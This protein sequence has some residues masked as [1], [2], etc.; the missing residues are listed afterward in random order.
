MTKNVSR[1]ER[2]QN[3]VEQHLLREEAAS[4]AHELRS[5]CRFCPACA[6]SGPQPHASGR[7]AA[8]ESL[9]AGRIVQPRSGRGEESTVRPDAD[10]LGLLIG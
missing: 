10:L 3:F 8:P 9:A 4:E 1:L 5:V 7:K 2:M 6:A